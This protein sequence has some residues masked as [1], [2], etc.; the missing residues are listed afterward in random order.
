MSKSDPLR[1][2]L[3]E[4]GGVPN[5]LYQEGQTAPVTFNLTNRFAKVSSKHKRITL[6]ALFAD[7]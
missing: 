5:V 6:C 4:L 2:I 3:A 1:G 7:F